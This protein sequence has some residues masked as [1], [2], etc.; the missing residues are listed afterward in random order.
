MAL[1]MT[2]F[3]VSILIVL[4]TAISIV[5]NLYFRHTG[6][7]LFDKKYKLGSPGYRKVRKIL[8]NRI[9]VIHAMLLP[10]FI[11]NLVFIID[12]TAHLPN[13]GFATVTFA[14]GVVVVISLFVV[15]ARAKTIKQ[16]V[17]QRKK[18]DDSWLS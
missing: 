9:L 17:E 18:K 12:K 1:Y 7:L 8:S 11:A 6:V 16:S 5:R 2:Y 3:I 4:F 10:I 15:L 13:R 14:V